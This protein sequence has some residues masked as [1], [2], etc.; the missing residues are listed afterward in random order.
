MSAESCEWMSSAAGMMVEQRQ[1]SGT[2]QFRRGVRGARWAD[3]ET[4]MRTAAA[5]CWQVGRQEAGRQARCWGGS[6][7]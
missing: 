7:C 5:G 2:A 6:G 3:G 4:R 1:I